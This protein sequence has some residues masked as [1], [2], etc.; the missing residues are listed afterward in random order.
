M[1]AYIVIRLGHRNTSD[2]VLTAFFSEE[3]AN[4]YIGAQA[5]LVVREVEI[6]DWRSYLDL[7]GI[8]TKQHT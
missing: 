1:K 3:H 6:Q 7:E 8:K 2:K 4:A 5:G